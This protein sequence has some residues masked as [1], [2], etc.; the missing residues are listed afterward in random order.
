M[1]D[2]P[3]P[4]AEL[5]HDALGLLGTVTLTAAYMAPAASLIALFG[6]MVGHVGTAVGT[7]MLLAM[8]I[9]LPSAISF[10]MMAREL[11]SAGSVS[12]WARM[13]LGAGFGDWIGL[14]TALYFL[15]TV[16]FPPI[17]F[18][19]LTLELVSAAGVAVPEDGQIYVWLAGVAVSFVVTG[20]ATYRG[21]E[22]SSRLAFVMLIV[23]FVVMSAL[24]AHFIARAVGQGAV[25]ASLFTISASPD[26]WSGVFLALPLAMLSLVCDAAVPVSEETRNARRTIPLA[27]ILTLLVVG[28]WNVLAFGAL[29][30]SAPPAELLAMSGNA[31]TN[32]VPLLAGRV[33]GSGNIIVTLVG[34]VAMLGALVPCSTAAS[35]LLYSLGRE[36]TLPAWL[37]WVHPRHQTPWHSLHAVF[38][39][40]IGAVVIPALA[41]GPN[42]TIGWWGSV[43]VWFILVVYF[44]ANL[45]NILYYR[46][47]LRDR[48]NVLWNL[49][50]PLVAMV[51]QIAIAWRVVGK[52]LWSAGW[53]G[54]SAQLFI[55]LASIACILQALRLNRQRNR[56][57]S[58]PPASSMPSSD[59]RRRP[60]VVAGHAAD[61][62]SK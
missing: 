14:V 60:A 19:Q 35:R 52:E 18:G 48:F 15:L 12:A 13:T 11:P 10:G 47:H 5:R 9:T 41:V 32:P 23:Q 30:V 54:R 55:V 25:S 37:T 59:E 36:G 31:V 50:C 4:A 58:P 42:P 43:V 46:R 20:Y 6:V 33:W 56:Y 38:L 1:P 22:V 28:A 45:C 3:S 24:A 61:S 51:I 21:I 57:A 53:S 26:G 39:I 49:L 40:S 27:I 17:V 16:F 62:I 8:L 2:H 44:T 29:A 34:M 7:V